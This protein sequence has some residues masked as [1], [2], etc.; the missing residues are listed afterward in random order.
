MAAK[1]AGTMYTADRRLYLD[2]E[3]RVCEADS[4]KRLSLLV[5]AGGQIP[6]E[7]AERLGLVA[8]E[9]PGPGLS[10]EDAVSVDHPL[11]GH[12][13]DAGPGEAAGLPPAAGTDGAP[14][15]EAAADVDDIP[16]TTSGSRRNSHGPSRNAR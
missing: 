9:P 13:V 11:Y 10:R 16:A 12:V 6:M 8:A 1:R 15:G 4:P 3:G 5:P 7:L 14:G 2:A